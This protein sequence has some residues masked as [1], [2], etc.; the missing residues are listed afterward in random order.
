M[1]IRKTLLATACAFA[2]ALGI[3]S[4]PASADTSA[5]TSWNGSGT[6][7]FNA[8]ASNGST[9]ALSSAGN[10]NGG[11]A[12]FSNDETNAYGY[13]VPNT[14]ANFNAAVNS[15]GLIQSSFTRDGSAGAYGAAGQSITS[16]AYSFDGAANAVGNLKSNYASISDVGY[17]QPHTADGKTLSAS[18]SQYTLTYNVNTGVANNASGMTISGNGSAAFAS[19][20]SSASANGYS[21]ANGG[22]IFTLA[23]I[24]GTGTGSF[25]YGGVG[26]GSVSVPGANLSVPGTVTNP[27]SLTIS[28]TW[29]GSLNLGNVSVNGAAH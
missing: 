25:S 20:F 8:N 24:T 1:N 5:N 15:G 22:G 17:G 14:N 13:G 19:N 21:L 3:A 18:G 7:T 4:A 11:T 26:T 12:Q 6:V 10:V 27:G 23:A 28:G 16:T 29:D 2:F 9:F